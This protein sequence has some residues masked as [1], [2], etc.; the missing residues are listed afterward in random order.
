MIR[1]L[2][3]AALVAVVFLALL[4]AAAYVAG[5]LDGGSAAYAQDADCSREI[6]AVANEALQA[7][8]ATSIEAG[9]AAYIATRCTVGSFAELVVRARQ[10]C[11]T[12]RVREKTG[13]VRAWGCG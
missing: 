2:A 13:Q 1:S 6:C 10:V 12:V 11:E 9:I 7:Q 4:L 3:I 8:I 5:Q